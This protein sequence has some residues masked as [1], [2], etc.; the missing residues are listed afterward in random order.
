MKILF[1][2]DGNVYRSQVAQAC[3]DN[4][5]QHDSESAG[6]RVEEWIAM[7]NLPGKKIKDAPT[8]RSIEHVRNEFGVDISEKERKQLT[9]DLVDEA[10]LVIVMTAKN[11]WPD[12]LNEGNKVVFW[13]IPDPWEH[14]DDFAYDVFKQIQHRVEKLVED[15]EGDE[16]STATI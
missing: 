14:D 15:I 7:L 16:F 10:D 4:L 5:S 3:F 2:C 13:D 12:Y 9:P 11:G 8:N 6:I 1:V